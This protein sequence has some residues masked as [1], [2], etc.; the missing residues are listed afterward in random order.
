VLR[1]VASRFLRLDPR[2][3]ANVIVFSARKPV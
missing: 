1:Y 2:L 3:F